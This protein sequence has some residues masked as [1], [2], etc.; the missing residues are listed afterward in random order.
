MTEIQILE[1][2][3][4]LV[5]AAGDGA[6]T[7][8]MLWIFKSY[9]AHILTAVC[10]IIFLVVGIKVLKIVLTNFGFIEQISKASGITLPFYENDKKAILKVLEDNRENIHKLL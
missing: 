8:T 7:L 2:L 6:F 3:F 9:L 10:F 1:K 4:S 5:G